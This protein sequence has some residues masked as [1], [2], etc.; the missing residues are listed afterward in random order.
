MSIGKTEK[1]TG[2]KCFCC[3]TASAS[4]DSTEEIVDLSRLAAAFAAEH[5]ADMNRAKMFGLITE[6]LAGVLTEHVFS[7][8]KKHNINAR[9]VAKG[10][11]LIIRIR[12]DCKPFDMT[13]YYPTLDDNRAQN[14]GLAIIM[15]MSKNV[16]STRTL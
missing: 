8:G 10:E 15:N 16:H 3:L 4:L 7:D 5:G 11:D 9:L 1:L 6:E 13:E 14:A 12:D 2:T